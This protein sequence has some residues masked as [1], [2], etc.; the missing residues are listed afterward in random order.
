MTDT[1]IPIEKWGKDHW[2]T[3]A[4]IETRAVDHHG[5]LDNRQ[6]QPRNTHYPCRLK[7]YDPEKPETFVVG[8]GDWGCLED[9]VAEGLVAP[10]P[11][12]LPQSATGRIPWSDVTTKRPAHTNQVR[13]TEKG[14]AIAGQL[15]GHKARGG[16]FATFEPDLSKIA[17]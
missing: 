17:A 15:R 10:G 14:I 11:E 5:Y 1:H 6:M 12:A 7:G 2:S 13:L 4:Y 8:H 16:N 3:F 9:M